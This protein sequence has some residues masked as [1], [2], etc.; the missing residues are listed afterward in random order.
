MP[1]VGLQ[2]DC[3]SFQAWLT[4]IKMTPLR[5]IGTLG[6]AADAGD[7]DCIPQHETGLY[8]FSAHNELLTS[9]VC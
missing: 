6:G 2:I 4:E 9:V 3:D 1:S 8:Q 7:I 5:K